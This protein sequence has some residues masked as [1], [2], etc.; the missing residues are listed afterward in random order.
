MPPTTP[1]AMAPA[2]FLCEATA[3]TAAEAE[4]VP[5]PVEV[6]EGLVLEDNVWAAPGV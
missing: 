3:T 5:A 4:G 1:P 6:S 2:L